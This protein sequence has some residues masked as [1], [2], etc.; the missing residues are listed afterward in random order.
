M[1]CLSPRRSTFLIFLCVECLAFSFFIVLDTPSLVIPVR[2]YHRR[3]AKPVREHAHDAGPGA[4]LQN[5]F[6]GQVQ[7]GFSRDDLTGLVF[8]A[9]VTDTVGTMLH[10][11]GAQQERAFPESL[12]ADFFAVLVDLW[13][14]RRR[15][16]VGGAARAREREGQADRVQLLRVFVFRRGIFTSEI[17]DRCCRTQASF[18]ARRTGF[19]IRRYLSFFLRVHAA[20]A[21]RVKTREQQQR[22]SDTTPCGGSTGTSES[23]G[24][25]QTRSL[26]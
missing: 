18:G 23:N 12:A 1:A 17:S 13:I 5:G 20:A 3:R 7:F 19:G 15:G 14:G 10:K 11:V 6:P 25:R 2:H 21:S 8:T 9:L 22:R 4:E 16:W 26:G 24:V